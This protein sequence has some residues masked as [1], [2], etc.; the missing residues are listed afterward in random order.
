MR[1]THHERLHRPRPALPCRRR[2]TTRRLKPNLTRE[3]VRNEINRR[4]L[5]QQMRGLHVAPN[6]ALVLGQLGT[7]RS[8]DSLVMIHIRAFITTRAVRPFCMPTTIIGHNIIITKE[9]GLPQEIYNQNKGYNEVYKCWTKQLTPHQYLGLDPNMPEG[10]NIRCTI[11]IMEQNHPT[12][13]RNKYAEAFAKEVEKIN[14][15]CLSCLRQ[16]GGYSF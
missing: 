13:T 12:K 15:L 5:Q 4:R 2:R 8:R 7:C 10:Y 1:R 14:K 3:Y 6:A 16:K 9:K 11:Q